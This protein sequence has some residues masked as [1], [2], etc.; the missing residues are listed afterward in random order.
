MTSSRAFLTAA[1]ILLMAGAAYAGPG[2]KGH[3]HDHG[4]TFGE[5][6]DPK[7]PARQV[8]VTMTEQDGKMLFLPN[9]I[10][11]K[12]GEQVRFKL[13]NKGLLDHE[14]VLATLEENLK[15]AK[16]MEK[17]QTWNTTIPMQSVLRRTAMEKSSGSSRKLGPLTFPASFQGIGSQ[18]CS[19]WSS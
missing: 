11:V 1:S 7:K 6:G 9:K 8:L 2:E 14:I 15:H 5:P 4:L 13:T 3:S 17:T 12:K 18:A 10:E 16:E 19:A